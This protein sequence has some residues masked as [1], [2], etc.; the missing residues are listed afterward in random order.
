MVYESESFPS[1]PDD[2][3]PYPVRSG[4]LVRSVKDRRSIKLRRKRAGW[5]PDFLTNKLGQFSR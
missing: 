2:A 1:I 3:G 5:D 4:Q